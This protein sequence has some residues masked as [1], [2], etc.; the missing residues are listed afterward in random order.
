MFRTYDISQNGKADANGIFRAPKEMALGAIE[1][2]F[3]CCLIG[4]VISR[5]VQMDKQEF[6]DKAFYTY[7]IIL[8]CLIMLLESPITY[9]NN[10]FRVKG[11]IGR[12]I[13][14]LATY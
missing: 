11:E 4:Y 8:D 2:V 6:H 7:W 10:I 12:N 3:D 9:F 5:L 1:I 13:S 14:T